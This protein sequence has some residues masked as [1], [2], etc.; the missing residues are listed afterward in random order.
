MFKAN[1]GLNPSSGKDNPGAP[2]A[3]FISKNLK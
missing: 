1:E 2:I 3:K